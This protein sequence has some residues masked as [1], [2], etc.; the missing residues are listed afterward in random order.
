MPMLRSAA[1]ATA[2]LIVSALVRRNGRIVLVHE[3]GPDDSEPCWMLPGGKVEAGESLLEALDRELREETGLRLA[4]DPSVAFVAHVLSAGDAC[5]AFTFSCLANG[6]L[7]P[8]DPDGYILD[9]AWV[10]EAEALQRLER[11]AWYDVA[12]LRRH[13]AGELGGAPV[14]VVDRR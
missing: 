13:L 3:V 5:V 8:D 1:M 14:S 6:A 7:T 11:V 2:H 10:E 12:P 4:G 9:V